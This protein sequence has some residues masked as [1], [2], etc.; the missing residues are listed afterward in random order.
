MLIEECRTMMNYKCRFQ[1]HILVLLPTEMFPRS[2]LHSMLTF[3]QPDDGAIN[4]RR[5]AFL[6]IIFW[7]KILAI[8]G[9]LFATLYVSGAI[10]I[11]IAWLSFQSHRACNVHL[12]SKMKFNLLCQCWFIASSIQ[13]KKKKK[14]SRNF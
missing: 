4:I 5:F 2:N 3:E 8:Y 7:I 12:V 11:I 9:I 13:L 6:C 1:R 14:T 10:F